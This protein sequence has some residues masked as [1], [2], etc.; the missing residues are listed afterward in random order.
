MRLLVVAV[1]L[2]VSGTIAA[3]EPDRVLRGVVVNEDTNEPIE[4]ALVIGQSDTATT[5]QD[6]G[7]A[8]VISADE[9]FLVVSAPGYAMRSIEIMQAYRV[10][11]TESH[12][13]IQVEGTAPRPRKRPPPPP[14]ALPP[15]RPAPIKYELTAA[16]LRTLPGTANDAL[17]AAQVLPG[18]ARLPYSFGGIVMRGTSPRDNAVYL[19][20]IE[21]PLAFHFGGISSF[22]PSN[23]LEGITVSN[24]GI[25]ASYGRAQGGI[26]EMHSREPRGDKWRTGGSVGLLDTSLLAEGPYKGG[27][28]MFGVRRSYLD[29]VMAPFV[30]EDV[31]LPSYLDAQIKGSF[32]APETTGR[33]RPIAFLA[34]DHLQAT[35]VKEDRED[36]S[37]VTAFFVRV[38][39]PY[40]RKWGRTTLR[41]VPWL[42][43]N[44]LNFTSRVNNVIEKFRRPIYPGG[45]RLELQRDYA[46]G[47][48]RGGIDMQGGHLTHFQAGLGHKGDILDQ[49]NGDTTID[50]LDAAIYGETRFMLGR[51]DLKPGLRFEHYGLSEESVIDPRLALRLPLTPSLT[52][53]ESLGRYHQPPTPGDIDPNGGN[54]DLESSY[55]DATSL[56]LELARGDWSGSVTGFYSDG[57]QQGVRVS[58]MFDFSN[59]GT[60]GP[61]FAQL[62]EKQLGLSFYREN[63]GRA[64]NYGVEVLIKRYTKYWFGLISYTL[65]KAERIDDPR[66]WNTK[67]PNPRVA[68][69]PR[70]F[71]LDQRHNLNIAGSYVLGKWRL[72]GRIQYVSGAPYSPQLLDVAQNPVFP[73]Y[74]ERLPDFFQLDVRADRM[75]KRCWG[76]IDLYFDIQNVTN[77]RN[78]EGRDIND[79]GE[80]TEVPGLPILP[81]IGL[82]FIPD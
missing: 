32:G 64:K 34:F 62:L 7:F 63:I 21:V 57:Q 29:V 60:L 80:E 13:V 2:V 16:D 47:D 58:S 46:W 17:R 11:L 66:Q 54:P 3:A 42:G 14:P 72:G 23:M 71:D 35:E 65:A 39:M 43:A 61:T 76:T 56:G 45:A 8:L 37:T 4:G 33:I 18:V 55:Y 51:L 20:G 15:E 44:H 19:D 25:D 6:G 22:Y 67:P 26:V 79:N 31:P 73:P 5:D 40:D 82:E 49:M 53:V 78:I 10:E 48:V 36:E 38:A 12:E 52:L 81:F 1:L 9:Q 27:A 70:P 59:L 24:G 74:S 68:R 30:D 77:R 75:W 69:G 50:W 28:V 41:F